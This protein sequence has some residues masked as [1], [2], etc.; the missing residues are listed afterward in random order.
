MNDITADTEASFAVRVDGRHVLVAD[1]QASAT[2]DIYAIDGTL[3]ASKA[4]DAYGAATIDVPAAG[5]Y[6]V[7]VAA[8][9]TKVS[10]R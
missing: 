6:I 4:T 10:I 8:A 5:I 2:V 9:A 7:R 3:V 1:A